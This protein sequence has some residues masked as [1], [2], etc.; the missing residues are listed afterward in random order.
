MSQHQNS[1]NV[2]PI[3][4]RTLT[5]IN[6]IYTILTVLKFIKRTPTFP[7]ISFYGIILRRTH[8][9]HVKEA[10]NPKEQNQLF[11]L[12]TRVILDLMRSLVNHWSP[13]T[14]ASHC[15]TTSRPAAATQTTVRVSP[16]MHPEVFLSQMSFLLHA[17][18]FLGLETGSEYAGFAHR[19]AGFAHR[20]AGLTML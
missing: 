8:R 2:N 20:E 11:L 10:E 4:T 1:H 15:V 7:R 16:A 3:Y 5:N 18:I 6:P 19:E 14:H 17:S 13:V 9:K 12:Y